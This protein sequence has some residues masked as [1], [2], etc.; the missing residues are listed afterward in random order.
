MSE[1]EGFAFGADEVQGCKCPAATAGYSPKNGDESQ[2]IASEFDWILRSNE[3]FGV[4]GSEGVVDEETAK[5]AWKA[6]IGALRVKEDVKSIRV[7]QE[8]A[9]ELGWEDN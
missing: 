3:R 5:R 7:A 9:E 2:R 6:A 1:R 8:I 4:D